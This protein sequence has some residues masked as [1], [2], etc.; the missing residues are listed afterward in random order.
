M[1]AIRATPSFI[2]AGSTRVFSSFKAADAGFTGR[3]G[4]R[5]SRSAVDPAGI[6]AGLPFT[7][8][9]LLF[10]FHHSALGRRVWVVAKR[11][12]HRLN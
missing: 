9:L 1:T 10:Y 5:R 3:Q 6:A 4:A 11:S 8:I 7:L 2:R 12:C